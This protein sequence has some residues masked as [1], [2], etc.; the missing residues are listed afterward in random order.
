MS[1]SLPRRQ[2]QAPDGKAVGE[3]RDLDVDLAAAGELGQVLLARRI[4]PFTQIIHLQVQAAVH[5]CMVLHR[6]GAASHSPIGR[7]L[8]P[9][10]EAKGKAVLGLQNE[11]VG[12][13][14]IRG[15]LNERVLQPDLVERGRQNSDRI[16]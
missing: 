15:A 2:L 11:A 7:G 8:D 14:P 9:V 4:V 12:A 10:V 5:A 3:R 6:K 13:Q 16:M 1:R